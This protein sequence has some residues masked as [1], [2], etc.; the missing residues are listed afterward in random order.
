MKTISTILLTIAATILLTAGTASAEE[1]FSLSD[2]EYDFF[3]V[4]QSDDGESCLLEIDPK[5]YPYTWK[6]L[7]KEYRAV[8][9]PICPLCSEYLV[10]DKTHNCGIDNNKWDWIMNLGMTFCVYCGEQLITEC[11][12]CGA[13]LIP[14]SNGNE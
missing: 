6:A 9:K 14:Y 11:S 10:G 2:I 5:D 3:Y 1:S 4:Y 13:K 12:C 8:I 7:K